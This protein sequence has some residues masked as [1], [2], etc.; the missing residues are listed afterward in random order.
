M[1]AL[2]SLKVKNLDDLTASSANGFQQ[3]LFN[4]QHKKLKSILVCAVYRPHFCPVTCFTE[5]FVP[6]YSQ[7]LVLRKD[8][9][10]IG[11]LNCNLL[12]NS[13]ESCARTDLYL[14]KPLSTHLQ[15]NL[16]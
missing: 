12:S 15:A 4:V 6:K 2:S 9:V 3:L 10:I 7:A 8:I 13:L 1:Y 14:I 5:D 11:D 16:N